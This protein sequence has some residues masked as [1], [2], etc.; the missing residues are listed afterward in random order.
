MKPSTCPNSWATDR[1]E[2]RQIESAEHNRNKNA[3]NEAKVQAAKLYSEL[4]ALGRQSYYKRI[5]AEFPT[6]S[7]DFINSEKLVTDTIMED[8]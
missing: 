5:K 2:V 6:A 7:D 1:L 8:G 4:S 3:V